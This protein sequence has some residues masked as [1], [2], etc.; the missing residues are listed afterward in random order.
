MICYNRIKER[1]RR[2]VAI[3]GQNACHWC[4]N[5]ERKKNKRDENRK[6][7]L[8]NMFGCFSFSLFI[9]N[10]KKNINKW[11]AISFCLL[12]LTLIRDGWSFLGTLKKD[13]F[14]FLFLNRKSVKLQLQLYFSATIFGESIFLLEL[15][16]M[17]H[18]AFFVCENVCVCMHSIP[19][20]NH[21][22][23]VSIWLININ[24][25]HLW[26]LVVHFFFRPL[27]SFCFFC[28]KLPSNE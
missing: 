6:S 25:N 27:F 18:F 1:R 13:L 10:R 23:N 16:K 8:I 15:S 14:F 26:R 22:I 5:V 20:T 28:E 21:L 9:W 4:K 17:R 12:N 24:F 7:I 11:F 3:H 2:P 19:F